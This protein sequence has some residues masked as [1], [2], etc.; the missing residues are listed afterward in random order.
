VNAEFDHAINCEEKPV[1][2]MIS[3]QYASAQPRAG[4]PGAIAEAVRKLSSEILHKDP[5]VTAIAIQE[6]DP[7]NW[8]V[9]DASLTRHKLGAFW[10]DI[11]I[12]DGTNT[13]EE[14]AAFIAAAFAKMNELIGPLHT[15]SYVHVNEV[16][17]DAYGFG[18]VTQNER[19][20]AGKLAAAVKK[21]AA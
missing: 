17:G 6:I 16:R 4:L 2:P 14:K 19:Y 7:A 5:A 18:G 11:R 3:I 12:T 20:I 13:R 1:M 9:A 15:E 21:A 8:F 10:L